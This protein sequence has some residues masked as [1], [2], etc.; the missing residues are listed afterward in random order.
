MSWFLV[1]QQVDA[2][3]TLKYIVWGTGKEVPSQLF[4][5]S[6][7][8]GEFDDLLGRGRNASAATAKLVEQLDTSLRS[9]I[10]YPTVAQDVAQY[11]L[12]SFRAWTDSTAD[13]QDAIH[14]KSLRWTPSW[15]ADASG[16]AAAVQEW[17]AK[18]AEV[19]PCRGSVV[20]PAVE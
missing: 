19:L 11:N 2:W 18:P 14:A 9:T 3:S 8:P 12:D 13:W 15:D 16:A 7:D 5:L 4:N 20:W 1:V 10:D 17:L 6:A